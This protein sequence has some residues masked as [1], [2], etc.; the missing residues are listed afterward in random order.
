M[1]KETLTCICGYTEDRDVKEGETLE[2]LACP[3]CEEPMTASEIDVE[4]I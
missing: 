3:T 4:E 2:G 1:P